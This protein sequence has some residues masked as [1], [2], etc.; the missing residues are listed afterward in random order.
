[1][2]EGSWPAS[3][4]MPA[5]LDVVLAIRQPMTPLALP[6]DALALMYMG[7]NEKS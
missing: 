1:M 6:Q 3:W 2:E 5:S 4:S 7:L